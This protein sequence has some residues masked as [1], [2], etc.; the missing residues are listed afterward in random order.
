MTQVH[1]LAPSV[2]PVLFLLIQTII[3]MKKRFIILVLFFAAFVYQQGY[4]QVTITVKNNAAYTAFYTVFFTSYGQSKSLGEK[5]IYA[6]GNQPVQVPAGATDIKIKTRFKSVFQDFDLVTI[7]AGRSGGVFTFKGLLGAVDHSWEPDDASSGIESGPAVNIDIIYPNG[8]AEL[9]RAARDGNSTQMQILI[10]KGTTHINTK[11]TRGY[12]PLHEAVQNGFLQGIDILLTAAAD[13]NSQNAQGE[14]PF[15]MAIRLGKKELAQKFIDHGYAVSTDAKAVEAAVKSRNAEMIKLLLDNKADAN[16]VMNLAMEQNNIPMVE[17]VMDNYSPNITIELYKKAVDARRFDLAKKIIE[18]KVDANQ[19]ID[20]AI[21][22]NAPDLVQA[23]MEKGGDAQK[24]LSFAI[25]NR[26]PDLAATAITGFGAKPD[27]VM[28][29]AIKQNQTDIVNLL[30]D[31]GANADMGLTYAVNNN[32]TNFIPLMIGKGAKVNDAQISKVAATGD[33]ALVKTLIDAG[34]NKDVALTGAMTAKKYQTATLI[35]QAGA[36][37]TNIVKTAVENNQKELLVAALD[38]GADANPGLPAALSTGKKDLA[39]LLF[40]AGAK[41][42]DPVLVKAAIAKA[43]L[44]IL[45]LM[46]DNQTDPNIGLS[47]A[48]ELNNTAAAQMLLENN[49]DAKPAALIATAVKNKNLQ[50]TEMLL[51]SGADARPAGLIASAAKSKNAAMV[52][53]LLKGGAMPQDGMMD[54]VMAND[55]PITKML[56]TAGANGKSAQLLNASVGKNNAELT[57]LLLE[58][59]ANP[60]DAVNTAVA[61][62]ANN[63]LGLLISKGADVKNPVYMKTAIK[64]NNLPIL[65]LLISAG[66]DITYKDESGN[67]YLHFAASNE[68]DAVVTALANAGVKVND[69]N[70]AKDAPIHIAVTQGRKEVELVEAFIAAGADANMLNGTG[71]KPL[72]LAKGTKIK[73]R[74][75]EAGGEKN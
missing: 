27:L 58:S 38:A 22:K 5:T 61:G 1:F 57:G 40:K 62:N 34:G 26:K 19:A 60:S 52:D 23:A 16:A 55:A 13:M 70:N 73:K 46:I 71:K 39:E 28:E 41:T 68:A 48:V 10:D 63:V 11:N 50:L 66:N 65:S 30:L 51:K 20:Y 21:L 8:D 54:A 4:A 56:L 43:D 14:T 31:N 24:A 74:L 18:S 29:D 44:S 25:A 12:T 42:N 15:V 35:I 7:S 53:A 3:K 75:K 67:N 64:N 33:N 49:A 45:K 32:K 69:L 17:M 36:T 6:G 72:D 37:P 47:A 2:P 59:G 9:H